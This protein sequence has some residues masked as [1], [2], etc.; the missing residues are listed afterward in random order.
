MSASI[1]VNPFWIENFSSSSETFKGI[2]ESLK[3]VS[4]KFKLFTSIAFE[5]CGIVLFDNETSIEKIKSFIRVKM[6]AGCPNILA[7]AVKTKH[8]HKTTYWALFKEGVTDV[9]CWE[10][11][12]LAN[13][14]VADR[15]ERWL[16]IE[17]LL[18]S[19]KI[20]EMLIGNS[21]RWMRSL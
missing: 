5:K 12:F 9:L 10:S 3:E 13:Q 7:I 14:V 17:R 20:K 16:T 21:D 4:L 19:P 8:I 6:N 1:S 18:H 2:T 15:I 11:L